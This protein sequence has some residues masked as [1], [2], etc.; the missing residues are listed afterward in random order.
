MYACIYLFIYLVVAVAQVPQHLPV[1]L[2]IN[3]DYSVLSDGEKWR[4][5]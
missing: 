2:G 4:L 3:R 1:V 5:V